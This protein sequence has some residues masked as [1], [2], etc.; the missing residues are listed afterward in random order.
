MIISTDKNFLF[1]H[2][3]KTGGSSIENTLEMYQSFEYGSTHPTAFQIKNWIDKDLYK[4]LYKFS[5]VRNPWDLQYSCW[6]YYTQKS[7]VPINMDFETYIKWKFLDDY[8]IKDGI[9]YVGGDLNEKDSTEHLRHGYYVHRVPQCYFLID[10]KGN[11]IIDRVINLETVDQDLKDISDLLDLDIFFVPKLN[12]SRED[13]DDYRKHYTKEMIEIVS[14]R[15]AADIKLF[16]YEFNNLV[17]KNLNKVVTGKNIKNYKLNINTDIIFSISNIPYGFYDIK[18]QFDNDADYNVELENYNSGKIEKIFRF[19]NS[20]LQN[21][22]NIIEET[23]NELVE[24][25]NND[26]ENRDI[27]NQK[28]ELINTLVDKELIYLNKLSKIKKYT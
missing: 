25:L 15:F 16:G 10:E 3:P 1:I 17:P 28:R 22:Q 5:S 6:T 20:N 23:K 8:N 27:I 13:G 24:L 4:S 21:I 7:D 2:I 19:Y 11:F 9:K 12:V 14:Q 26:N 18:K